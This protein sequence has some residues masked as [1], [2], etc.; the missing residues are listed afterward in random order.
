MQLSRLSLAS[1]FTINWHKKRSVLQLHILFLGIFIEPIRGC[2]VDAGQLRMRDI[3]I[4]P[5]YLE[6][7]K[8]VEEQC[9]L[10]ARQSA[11]IVSLLQV[12]RLVSPHCWVSM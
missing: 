10:A 6:R 7:I 5:L 1:P 8:H 2:L 9:M 12:D 4:E 3:P 11:R